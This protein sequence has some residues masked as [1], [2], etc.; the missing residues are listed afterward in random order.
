MFKGKVFVRE[1]EINESDVVKISQTEIGDVGC[2]VWDAAL[3]LSSYLQTKHC[4]D[5]ISKKSDDLKVIE[6]GSGTGFC[7]IVSGCLG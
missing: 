3:V 1:F 2:V 6:L 4:Q 5:I 7:G